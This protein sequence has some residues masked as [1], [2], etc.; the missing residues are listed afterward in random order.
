M[1]RYSALTHEAWNLLQPFHKRFFIQIFL[2]FVLAGFAVGITMLSGHVFS[3]ISERNF[4]SFLRAVAALFSGALIQSCLTFY[5]NYTAGKYLDSDI[6]QHLQ[7]IS[8]T[9]I[10][11]LTPQ[12]HSEDHSALKQQV[13]I[14][15]EG[16]A[17]TIVKAYINDIL[18]NIAYL[19][20]ALATMF[21]YSPLLGIL[22]LSFSIILALWIHRFFLFYQPI[23][24][25]NRD[26]WNEQA[27][28]RTEAFTHLHLI[29]LLGRKDF[30]L[31]KYLGKRRE[32]ADFGKYSDLVSIHHQTRKGLFS[33]FTQNTA[34][35]LA[36]LLAFHGTVSIAAMYVVWS[37][38]SHIFW[39]VS[40]LSN[41]VR[42]FPLRYAELEQYVHVLQKAPSFDEHGAKGVDLSQTISV[43]G[44]SFSYSSGGPVLQDLSFTIPAHKTTAFVGPSGSGK[45]T[46]VKL[47][48]RAYEYHIG[49]IRIGETELHD[50]DA[51]YLRAR[52]GYVE[53]HVD[54][55]DDTIR[56]NMLIAAADDKRPQAM[57]YLEEVTRLARIDQF[58]H[59][60]GNEGLDTIV[61]ER[62]I[63][64][65]GGERQRVGIARAM[66][67]NPDILIFDEATSA[68][69]SE[70]ERYVMEAINAVSKGKTALIIA[71]RLSTVRHADQ[72]IVMNKG[73][74]VNIG[75]HEELLGLS[76]VYQNLVAH[77]LA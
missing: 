17:E 13:I 32:F 6:S 50:I 39:S 30:F 56:E 53:Q 37:V 43:R 42:E 36:G 60:L 23:I 2:S 65:S 33:D 64:L 40:N 59:R 74:I 21:L 75:T 73:H 45:S 38:S 77:Q 55:M 9:R 7:E 31:K 71:H 72:I 28:S 34:L 29:K 19:T 67:K 18:P 3:A 49:S 16:A 25:K 24:K 47:L 52:I 57:S 12:Q 8:L 5:K 14:R 58:Y 48:M 69:D 68:L 63:K 46:I 35:L 76:P 20:I 26:N 44:L 15:G 11:S 10:L 62:G 1:Y 54:L 4:H 61:G 66:I 22:T 51:D 27:R 70:N 41:A